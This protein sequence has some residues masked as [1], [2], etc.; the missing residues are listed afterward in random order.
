MY[1]N[2]NYSTTGSFKGKFI[3]F[4]GKSSITEAEL[5]FIRPTEEVG[6]FLKANVAY[7]FRSSR[8]IDNLQIGIVG[9][10][11][12]YKGPIFIDNIRIE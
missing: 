11:T 7:R 5:D 1:F 2:P 8:S 12:N 6:D 10:V 3:G 4:M 9:A